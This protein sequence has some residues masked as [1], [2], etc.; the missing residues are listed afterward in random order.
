M[1]NRITTCF[2]TYAILYTLTIFHGSNLY[3][4]KPVLLYM[5]VGIIVTC[6]SLYEIIM[7]RIN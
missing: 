5:Y 1:S 6:N 4:Y 2:N 3:H 7:Y